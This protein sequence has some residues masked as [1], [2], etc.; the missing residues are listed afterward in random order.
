[1]AKSKDKKNKKKSRKAKKLSDD[2][3]ATLKGYTR[4]MRNAM[5]LGLPCCVLVGSLPATVAK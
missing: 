1:M 3:K 4:T 2:Q 5:K